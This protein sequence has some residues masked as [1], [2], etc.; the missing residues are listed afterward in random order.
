M[1]LS[2]TAQASLQRVIEQFKEGDLSPIRE[3][4]RIQLD[5]AAPA[6]KWSLSNKVLAFIQA[7]ELDCRGF[8]QWEQVGRHVK[9]GSNAIYILRPRLAKI[10]KLEDKETKEYLLCVGFATLPVF[11]ASETDGNEAIQSYEPAELPPLVEV[12]K[13]LGIAVDYIP[14]APDRLGDCNPDGSKIRIGTH[15]PSVFFHELAHA[16]HARIIGKLKG[17]QNSEQETVAEFTAAVLMDIYGLENH[18]GN[19]WR[20]ISH[21]SD[22]PLVAITKALG[23][24]EKVLAVLFDCGQQVEKAA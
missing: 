13:S 8:R 17:G 21:Y 20:Y 15:D 22:D 23:T 18:T 2:D 19:A 24:V 9:K 14:V 10:T 5:T 1:K 11:A 7:G 6:S 4:V 3:V 12:A 16:I